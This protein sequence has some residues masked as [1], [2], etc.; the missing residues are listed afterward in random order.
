MNATSRR[1]ILAF[2]LGRTVESNGKIAKD[3]KNVGIDRE[4]V[5][6]LLTSKTFDSKLKHSKILYANGK[7][8]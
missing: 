4:M 8:R 1:R 6:Y 3:W 5:H 2:F 7:L